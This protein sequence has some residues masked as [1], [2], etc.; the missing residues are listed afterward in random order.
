MTGWSRIYAS[1]QLPRLIPKAYHSRKRCACFP[2]AVTA[3][4]RL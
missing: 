4:S 3:L 1:D 2:F